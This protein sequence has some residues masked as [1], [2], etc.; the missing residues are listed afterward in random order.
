MNIKRFQSGVYAANCYIMNTEDGN[1]II[2]DPAEDIHG[3]V[4]YIENNKLI[5]EAIILTHG[6]GDHIGGVLA[7]K[8]KFNAPVMVHGLDEEMVKDEALNLSASMPMGSVSFS[9]DRLLK[10]GEIIKLGNKEI[11]VI[12]TPGHTKGGICL[13]TDNILITGDTLFQSSIGRTD[14]FGGDFETLIE[15][16]VKKLMVL[17]EDTIVYPG[18]GER[19]TIGYEKKN[20]SFIKNRVK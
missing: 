7:L 10:N 20:N 1:A 11:K 3:I 17:P 2:V 9:P 14:L 6:H 5:I 15:S 16:I 8:E 18:H 4:D 12:H 19:S 13:Y